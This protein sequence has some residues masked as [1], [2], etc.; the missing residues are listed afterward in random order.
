MNRLHMMREND[1]A[2]TTSSEDDVEGHGLLFPVRSVTERLV[3]LCEDL[4]AQHVPAHGSWLTLAQVDMANLSSEWLKEGSAGVETVSHA[5][6][7]TRESVSL[8]TG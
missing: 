2:E 5:A 6:G 4:E 8:S 7:D 1:I 3:R